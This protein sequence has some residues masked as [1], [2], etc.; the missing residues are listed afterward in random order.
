MQNSRLELNKRNT[1][2]IAK[3]IEEYVEPLLKVQ[4]ISGLSKIV[5]RFI[6]SGTKQ[7]EL[8]NIMPENKNIVEG[9]GRSKEAGAYISTLDTKGY[10]KLIRLIGQEY[11]LEFWKQPGLINEL[12]RTIKSRLQANGEKLAETKKNSAGRA[13]H[14]RSFHDGKTLSAG[15]TGVEVRLNPSSN[16]PRVTLLKLYV[17]IA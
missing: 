1:E 16:H 10:V 17:E 15:Y 11:S 13:W 8:K 3:F 14:D 6:P 9:F 12:E 2:V 7:K 4:A 5:Y